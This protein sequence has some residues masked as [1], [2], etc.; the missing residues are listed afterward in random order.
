MAGRSKTSKKNSRFPFLVVVG[1]I[2]VAGVIVLLWQAKKRLEGEPPTFVLKTPIKSIGL[3]HTLEGVASDR[4]SGL[5]RLWVAIMQRGKEVVL[6]DKAFPAE[7]LLRN[8]TVQEHTVSIKI[9]VKDLDFKDGKAIL[10]ATVWDYSYR[11]WWSGNRAY[12]EHEF[13]IDTKP[14]II[15]V[16]THQHNLNQG[17]T[18]LT[19]YTASEPLGST[20]VWVGE[21][22]FPGSTGY[23][24]N[25]DTFLAF[26]PLSYDKGPETRLYLSATDNA[27][28]TSQK[29]FF[30]YINAKRF[31][32]DAI[33]LSDQFLNQKMP[34]FQGV[35]RWDNSSTSLLE[36][37]LA[38]NRDQRL[39]DY[40]II[41]RVCKESDPKKYWEGSFLRLPNSA[42][43]AGFA[44]HRSYKYKGKTVDKQ[45]HL[46]IDLASIARSPVPAA[47]S[48]RIAFAENLGIYGQTVIIDH[49]FAI[50]SMYS[51]LS[52]I[53]VTIDQVVSKG[54]VIGLTGSTG[55]A[56]GDHLHFAIL[57]HNTFVNPIEW[58]D[59][60]W[61]KHNVTS[62]L[63][64]INKQIPTTDKETN[65]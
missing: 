49:G 41:Q 33:N 32:H 57:V 63:A 27:G 19:V 21:R 62:K 48:G 29:G 38:V 31:K 45:V 8:G 30:H 15:D 24:S 40:K 13:I 61:I 36:K 51:H 17:G 11:D 2:V 54:D 43:K 10:R 3:S 22:F 50:F 5:K 44:D 47:N 16:L 20:G 56:G 9:N 25:S 42:R 52:R 60:D 65:Q 39:A 64:N 58:W 12:M 37:F 4:K 35:M 7:G 53:G 1:I 59:P 14:P 28:N 34:E 26:F 55:M 23:F 18:G 6:L 46:G